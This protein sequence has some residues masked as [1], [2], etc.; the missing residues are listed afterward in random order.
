MVVSLYDTRTLGRVVDSLPRPH[1][2]LLERFFPGVINFQT[3]KI[4]FDLVT[5]GRKLAPFVSPMAQGKIMKNRGH[6]TQTFEPA[7]LKPKH[8]VDPD[9]PFIRMPGESYGAGDMSP[10]QRRDAAIANILS[11]Q[12]D[13]I[14]RRLEWMAAEALMNGAVTVAGDDYPTQVVDF[15]RDAALGIT[16]AGLAAWGQA[17]V[18]PLDNLETWA[19]LVSDKS[20]GAVTDVIFTAGSWNF[21]RQDQKLLDRLDNRRQ[22]S[23][24]VELGP[25]VI[26]PKARSA[27]NL[28]TIGDLELWL[29]NDVY[30]DDAGVTQKMLADN[31]VLLAGADIEGVQTYGAIQDAHAGYQATSRFHKNWITDDPSV[32][33]VMTQSAPLVVPTRP[34][35]SFRAIVA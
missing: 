3:K 21:A 22:L 14:V 33:N 13:S 24:A 15:G 11:D 2:F 29:Y 20:G 32:E 10:D 18:S 16:L 26:A 17:G 35:A 1:A 6:T 12:D 23:G 5:K 19:G 34:N 25:T 27:R 8:I 31:T 4:D 9:A 28:G 7:Y 30:E